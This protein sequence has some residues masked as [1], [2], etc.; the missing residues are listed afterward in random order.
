MVSRSGIAPGFSNLFDYA[1]REGMA[2]SLSIGNLEMLG[3]ICVIAATVG[4]GIYEYRSWWRWGGE[5]KVTKTQSFRDVRLTSAEW[6]LAAVGLTPVVIAAIRETMMARGLRGGILPVIP[7][8][9]E[10]FVL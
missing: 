9:Y 5:W 2:L 3:Y 1:A 10:D 6:A 8:R 4:A 7:P